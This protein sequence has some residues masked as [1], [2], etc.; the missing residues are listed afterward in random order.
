MVAFA[1]AL[2]IAY[3]FGAVFVAVCVLDTLKGQPP[4]WRT[5]G[6]VLLIA[7]TWPISVPIA[8]RS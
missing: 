5:A 7:F 8:L 1:W 3:I 4:S 6:M 2:F